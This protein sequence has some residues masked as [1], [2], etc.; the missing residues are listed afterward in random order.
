MHVYDVISKCVIFSQTWAKTHL[1][2][3]VVQK[4][5]LASL[6][7]ATREKEGERRG[8]DGNGGG[9]GRGGEGEGKVR[10]TSLSATDLRPLSPTDVLKVCH[11]F[12]LTINNAAMD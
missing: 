9:E 2:A 11:R 6:S 1:R 7:L 10:D 12:E 8:G 4:I 5:F 3:S